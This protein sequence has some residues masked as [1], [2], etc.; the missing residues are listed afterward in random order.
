MA[1]L[2]QMLFCKSVKEKFPEYFTGKIVVDIGSLDVNGNNQYLFESCLY[3]GVDVA[4]GK[5]VDFK[6]KGHEFNL[7]DESIDVIVSTECFEH[8]QYYD[9]TL[10]NCLRMLKPG[11]LLLFTC[12]TTGRPEHG[13]RRT[14]PKDAPLLMEQPGWCDYYRNLTAKDIHAAINIESNFS[15]HSFSSNFE[16]FDLYFYGIKRGTYESR[17]DASFLI[18]N[19][20]NEAYTAIYAAELQNRLLTEKNHELEAEQIR[21]IEVNKKASATCADL[22]N[23]LDGMTKKSD[24]YQRQFELV[25]NSHSWKLTRPFRTVFRK[26]R[27]LKTAGSKMKKIYGVYRREGWSGISLRIR[28]LMFSFRVGDQDS[29]ETWFSQYACLNDENRL[30]IHQDIATFEYLPLISILM[31]VY[32]PGLGYLQQAVESVTQQLYGR[33]ELCIADD[34]SQC[35]KTEA[36]LRSLEKSDRRIK[37]TFRKTNGHIAAASNTALDMAQGDYVAL[38]DQDDRLAEDA[39]YRVVKAIHSQPSVVLIY[40]DE[41]KIDEHGKHF[42]PHFKPDWN[43]TLFASYNYLSHLSVYRTDTLKQLAGFRQG[44]DGAQDYE[45]AARVVHQAN[46]G[47]IV[48]IARILYHWRAIPGSTACGVDEKP[49][50]VEASLKLLQEQLHRRGLLGRVGYLPCGAYRTFGEFHDPLP[51]VSIIIP[52]RNRIDMVERCIDSIFQ[53]TTYEN[54]EILL[55]DN[56]SDEQQSIDGFK[57]LV[58]CYPAIRLIKED[59]LA[60]NFSKINNYAVRFAR[61]EVL[62]LL[63]NDTE[64]ISPEWLAEL[65]YYAVQDGVGAVGAKLLYGDDTLQH[66]GVVLGIGGVAGHVHKRLPRH[67]CGYF[68]RACIA[69]EFSAV[70][71]ACLAVRKDCY[72]QVGGLDE[73]ALSV[74]FND[75]DLC[76]KLKEAGYRNIMTPFALLYHHESVS[77]GYEDT[78]EKYQRFQREIDYM[79][80]RWPDILINDPAYN[81]N[82]TLVHEDFSLASQPRVS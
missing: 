5:N 27:L 3:L 16:A 58:E 53:K 68:S 12:A 37:V 65:V 47:Q 45:L 31:P 13:T 57:R 77:R 25:M 30:A 20:L 73:Q 10:K 64:V 33:W 61:G 43:F 34:F 39:L 2:Q 4:Y 32:K 8:D 55:V 72:L 46:P 66:A 50:A 7:P 9:L 52:T 22:T 78:P 80:A 42:S 36:F 63:N 60:F 59:T 74:A 49:Y 6:T 40:T 18:N 81:P 79:K 54:F 29:Y 67:S 14:T 1:H 38:L 44:Y 21:L 82:L 35:S 69:Q 26:L 19:K 24:H 76:L 41:D 56:C 75:V 48:H 71:A 28:K 62:V 17:S 70:T 11:G 23:S 51:L 15:M